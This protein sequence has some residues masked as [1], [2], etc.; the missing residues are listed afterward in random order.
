MTQEEKARA[1][2]KAIEKI[3]YVMEHSVSPVLNKEDLQDIFPELAESEDERIKRILKKV[4]W[5]CNE[6]NAPMIG[7]KE[8]AD[9][10]AWLE[11]QG[12]TNETI[13]MDEFA[14][15][16]L[17][18]AAI[19]LIT[20]IDYN[21]AEG[22]MCLS[23]TECKDIGDALVRGDW[24]KIYAYMKK[25]LEKQSN[26]PQGK[27]A[28]EAVKEEKVDNANYVSVNKSFNIGD[29]V[30]TNEYGGRYKA[31]INAFIGNGM[32][33][34]EDGTFETEENLLKDYHLWTIEDAK[35]GDV[36]SNGD[37][38]LI[39]KEFEIPVY[40]QYIIAYIGL[41]TCG[42]IQVTDGHWTL[43]IDKSKPANKEQRDLLFKKIKE[44]G[45]EWDAKKKEL[46]KIEKQGEQKETLCDKCKKAQYSHSC[47]DIIA[48]GR[49]YIEGINT[50]NKVEP[51]W[52]DD[53]NSK[54]NDETN[55]PT[56]YGKYVDECLNEASKHFF[57]DGEDKYSVA[58]LFYAGVRCGKSWFE[59]QGKLNQVN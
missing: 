1:Y 41:D 9:C 3:K 43:G 30:V 10:I 55:A 48:L 7:D 26:K 21:A 44:A 29:W 46:R 18:G 52:S 25:K 24:H 49:C 58:D 4:L 13:N 6:G 14:Q 53:E 34:F 51:K 59:K 37:M 20:W 2:D 38:I 28:L 8:V 50:S 22:N 17:R 32:V 31:K 57:S 27:T 56:G 45:Y 11:K 54:V 12:N 39:F 5:D 23:N 35:D 19:N 47:Q 40:K 33:E 42:H 15:G 36:L 16:V